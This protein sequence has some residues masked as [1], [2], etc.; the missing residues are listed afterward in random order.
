MELSIPESLLLE[1][2]CFLKIY[3]IS[4][5]NSLDKNC[6]QFLKYTKK[7]PKKSRLNNQED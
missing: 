7:I 6:L 5:L 2:F 4:Y 1:F 3:W